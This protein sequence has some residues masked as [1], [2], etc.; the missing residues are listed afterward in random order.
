MPSPE[1]SLRP[2]QPIPLVGIE[3]K[4]IGSQMPKFEWHDPKTLM[5]ESEYQRDLSQRSIT[6]IRHIAGNFDWLHIKPPVCAR[7]AGGKL[8]VVDGQHTAIAAAS[9][10]V[11]KIPVMI[12]EAPEMKRRAKAFVAHN[13]DRLAITPMQ[14]FHSRVAAGDPGALAVMRV[15]AASAV[16]V[17][18]SQPATGY[19]K[20]GETVAIGG[21]ES[22]IRARGE[23]KSVRVLKTLV[24]AKR[25]PVATHEIRAVE[26]LLFDP[27]YGWQHSVFDL[28]TVVR[29]RSIDAW[30]GQV[31]GRMKDDEKLPVWKA[32]AKAWVR[33]GNRND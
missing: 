28:V 32:V 7:G 14:L 19:W 4:Q 23:E 29:S 1:H 16:T 27:S 22:L 13:T 9:R 24:A 6:L 25:G 30:R 11:P 18:R 20:V 17:C 21:I 12:I 10:G 15:A 8:C 2:I 5:V 3:P 33:A 26:A 31:I